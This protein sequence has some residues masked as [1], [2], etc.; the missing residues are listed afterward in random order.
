M[1]TPPLPPHPDADLVRAMIESMKDFRPQT[2]RVHQQ[3]HEDKCSVCLEDLDNSK[4]LVVLECKH[5]YH[6]SCM[7]EYVKNA[8]SD[9]RVCAVC[10]TNTDLPHILQDSL[11]PST[12]MYKRL[13]EEEKEKNRKLSE[14]FD[15]LYDATRNFIGTPAEHPP[16]TQHPRRRRNRHRTAPRNS[17][18]LSQRVRRQ[19]GDFDIRADNL[20]DIQNPRRY[21]NRVFQRFYERK[22]RAA[23]GS[24][25]NFGRDLSLEELRNII[26]A[27]SS[28]EMQD[29]VAY[30]QNNHRTME[31]SE[32]A[33]IAST[34]PP[35]EVE[36]LFAQMD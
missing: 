15:H 1:S 13:Y 19:F 21:E 4:P 32:L 18:S 3:I 8:P 31:T 23:P 24:R 35:D 30:L 10:R 20:A 26:P 2:N 33:Q 28:S 27:L 7:L 25:S 9:V 22:N 11:P 14:E 17:A 12:Q 16:T 36:M 6:L 29:V 5:I 34:L